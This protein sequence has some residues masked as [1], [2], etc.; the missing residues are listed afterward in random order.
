MTV[1]SFLLVCLATAYVCS[2]I[3][4]D[5]PMDLARATLRLLVFLAFGIGAFAGVIQVFTTLAG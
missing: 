2:A 1:V 5:E 4:E 3:K